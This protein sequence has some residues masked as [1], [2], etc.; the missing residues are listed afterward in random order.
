MTEK[1]QEAEERRQEKAK[2]ISVAAV[3]KHGETIQAVQEVAM[4]FVKSAE[5]NSLLTRKLSEVDPG[6][7][8]E[9][10]KEGGG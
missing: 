2:E 5:Q 4:K 8:R 3:M 10:E 6:W 9:C 7:C 1:V